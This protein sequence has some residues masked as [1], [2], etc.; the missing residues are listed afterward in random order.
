MDE[1]LAS[2]DAFYTGANLMTANATI[3]LDGTGVGAPTD[4]ASNTNIVSLENKA[5]S[6]GKLWTFIIN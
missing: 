1:L 3:T 5:T 6:Q 4:G 2:M